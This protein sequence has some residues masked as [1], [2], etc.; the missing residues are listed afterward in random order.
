MKKGPITIKDIAHKMGIS[1]TTVSRALANSPLLRQETKVIVKALAEQYHYVPNFQA[2]SLKNNKTNTIGIII[3]K[4]VHEF[5][6]KV[7][8]GIE[9]YAQANRYN[10]ILCSSH[11]SYEREV[12]H[13]KKLT[14]GRVDGIIACISNETKDISH[15]TEC[16][17]REI[18]LVFFD[19]VCDQLSVPKVVMDD[20]NAGYNA[21]NHL[22]EQGCQHI[23]YLG[24]PIDVSVN[25]NRHQGYLKALSE[26]HLESNPKAVA[27]C[28]TDTYD[29]GKEHTE[30]LLN[31]GRIDGIFASTD[32]LAIAAIKTV[33]STG[34]SVPDD[35]AVIGFSN[36]AIGSLFEPSLTTMSQPGSQ[37]GQRAAQ[38]L[39]EQINDPEHRHHE[40]IVIHSDLLVRESSVRVV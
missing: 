17:E 30:R 21:T 20:F 14:N 28:T 18:P 1:I 36:W 38:S 24:G 26:A 6:S 31:T 15:F 11:D 27:H 9:E 10:V 8:R 40:E 19:C 39:L 37:I 22:I 3:P 16:V 13:V 23:A 32:M 4:L 25:I 34:L 12:A 35:I 33:V 7:V 5:F 2:L 29:Y